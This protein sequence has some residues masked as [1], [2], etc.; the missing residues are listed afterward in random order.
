MAH[1]R[2]VAGIRCTLVL[3]HLSDYIDD[4][5]DPSVRSMVDAHLTG[6]DWCTRF[7]GQFAGVVTELR[8][9]LAAP[10]VL[11]AGVAE[12]LAAAIAND[13]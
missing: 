5:L 12:R 2:L 7:G 11:D 8:A 13:G 4:Q 9:Q 6:C 10:D 3:E 1:D